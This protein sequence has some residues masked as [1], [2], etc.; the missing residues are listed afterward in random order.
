M[1]AAIRTWVR[2]WFNAH[3]Q[4]LLRPHTA[5]P[6]L[7]FQCTTPFPGKPTNR[8]T[9]DLQ[10]TAVLDRAL[11]SAAAKFT[12]ELKK[13]DT[14]SLDWFK[15]QYYFAY[16]SKEVVMYVSQNPRTLYKM[17]QV[18]TALVDSMI[19]FAIIDIPALGLEESAV[20]VRR[21]FFVQLRRFSEEFDL[22][23]NSEALLKVATDMLTVQLSLDSSAA[24]LKAVTL[25]EG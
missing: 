12:R 22:S 4:I 25:D 24:S 10:E 20:N 6:I 16:R 23:T 3:Q 5:Y 9:Y 1:Q 17:L 19:K 14:T 7:V 2:A 13:L 18:E 15:R 8:F 21:A 11:R